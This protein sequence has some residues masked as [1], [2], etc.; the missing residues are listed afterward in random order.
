[1][2]ELEINV[3]IDSSYTDEADLILI[4]KTIEYLTNVHDKIIECI[5]VES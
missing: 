3:K 2:I 5:E 4:E 1:M